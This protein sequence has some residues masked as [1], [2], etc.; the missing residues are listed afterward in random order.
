MSNFSTSNVAAKSV[1]SIMP[2]AKLINE[3]GLCPTITFRDLYYS[4]D[5]FEISIEDTDILLKIALKTYD[6]E[7][8]EVILL[9]IDP[10]RCEDPNV[11]VKDL[12]F[13]FNEEEN[14]F[15]P[16]RIIQRVPHKDFLLRKAF[17]QYLLNCFDDSSLL[18]KAM[19]D[20]IIKSYK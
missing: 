4:R 3:S 8:Q 19:S 1:V 14:S 13:G 18:D 15:I 16:H 20:G 5:D 10:R 11:D 6:T 12:F 7:K 17:L 2:N 9:F